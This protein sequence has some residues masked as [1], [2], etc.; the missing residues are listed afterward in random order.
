MPSSLKHSKLEAIQFQAGNS[1][2]AFEKKTN[3]KTRK[4]KN[5]P[6]ECWSKKI[7]GKV[8]KYLLLI[9]LKFLSSQQWYFSASYTVLKHWHR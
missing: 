6:V 7:L 3:K 8:P 9:F 1:F 5:A 2:Y 4:T